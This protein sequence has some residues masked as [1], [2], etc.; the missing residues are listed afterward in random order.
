VCHDATCASPAPGNIN[1]APTTGDSVVVDTVTGLSGQIWGNELGWID[2]HPTGQGVTFSDPVTG[3][4]TGKAWSQV[5][6][7]INF[8]PTG[9]QVTINPSTGEFSGYAWTGGPFGGWIKF[10]CGNSSSCVKTSWAINSPPTVGQLPDVCKNISGWQGSIP[11]GYTVNIDGLCIPA[12]DACPNLQGDQSSIPTDF[13]VN[14]IGSCVP[15]IDY[16]P[17]IKGVQTSVPISYVVNSKGN[18]I[19]PKIG[20]ACPNINGIQEKSSDC[21]A[22]DFCVNIDGTQ[23]SIPDG[24]M[25][26]ENYCYPE[27]IDLCKNIDGGQGSVPPGFVLDSKS[28]CVEQLIDTCRNLS[29][30]QDNVPVGFYLS[31][32]NLCLFDTFDREVENIGEQVISFPFIPEGFMIPSNNSFLKDLVQILLGTDGNYRVDL[33]S[34]GISL[35]GLVLA[36]FIIKRIL[37][38]LMNLR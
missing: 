17:N 5:S 36:L 35:V 33:V 15:D 3:V 18:C 20:D 34:A 16:C 21:N 29:G 23:T 9:Q 38:I 13:T 8:A 7:W 31:E 14:S 2:L 12:Y 30:Q 32:D 22:D 10:D 27:N 6:G 28:N 4:L 1:F 11:S 26:T 24:Y 25:R 19:A 37:N